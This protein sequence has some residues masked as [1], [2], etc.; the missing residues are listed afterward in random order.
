LNLLEDHLDYPKHLEVWVDFYVHL[1]STSVLKQSS[2]YSGSVIMSAVYSYDAARRDDYMVE[3]AVMALDIILKEMRPEVAA[4]FS[5]F[6]SRTLGRSTYTAASYCLI[7]SSPP[8]LL[9]P[10]YAPQ[11]SFTFSQ[12]ISLGKLGESICVH[13]AWS[14]MHNIS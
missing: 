5:A 13:G 10:W 7:C 1:S 14:G 6:P 3:R 2:S 12:G 9:A 4:I 8:S 11:E